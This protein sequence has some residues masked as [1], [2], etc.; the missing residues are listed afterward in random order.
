MRVIDCFAVLISE[1]FLIS[2]ADCRLASRRHSTRNFS[3][4]MNRSGVSGDSLWVI[5]GYRRTPKR[6]APD[7]IIQNSQTLKL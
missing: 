4:E 7:K 5:Y 6:N 3:N 2:T 1:H